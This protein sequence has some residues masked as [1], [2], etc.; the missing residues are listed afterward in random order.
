MLVTRRLPVDDT[1]HAAEQVGSV[2]I[3]NHAA[4]NLFYR[5]QRAVH[6]DHS[7]AALLLMRNDRKMN[8]RDGTA[9]EPANATKPNT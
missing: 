7:P 3:G 4:L 8:K 6:Y 5:R 2:Q 1:A 9:G